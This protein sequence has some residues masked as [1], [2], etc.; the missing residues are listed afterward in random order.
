MR[1]KIACENAKH[2][3]SC[4][5]ESEIELDRLAEGE[6]FVINIDRSTFNDLCDSLFTKCISCVKNALEK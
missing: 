3:L 1:L 6:D 5:E 2:D 4:M